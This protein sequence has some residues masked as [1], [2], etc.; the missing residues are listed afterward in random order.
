MYNYLKTKIIV[1]S[2]MSHLYLQ[3]DWVLVI[4]PCLYS[5]PES[6]NQTLALEKAFYVFH[7][8]Y[9]HPQILTRGAGPEEEYSVKHN[10]QLHS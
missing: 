6:T 5:G 8:F 3:R 4:L 1:L 2:W 7:I 9:S 10:L